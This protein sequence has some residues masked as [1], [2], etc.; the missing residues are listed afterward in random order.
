MFDV[1]ALDGENTMDMPYVER[2]ELLE[3][4][5]LAGGFWFLPSVFDDGQA[6]FAAVC[7][8]ELEGIVATLCRLR[9][10]LGTAFGTYL[11]S[12]E[13]ISAHPMCLN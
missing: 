10:Q 6:L 4:L 9:G 2:R 8:Q 5:D 1:R 11:T 7:E 13:R 12:P 3:S